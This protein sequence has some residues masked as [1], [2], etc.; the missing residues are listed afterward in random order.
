MIKDLISKERSKIESEG[1]NIAIW[2]KT[3]NKINTMLLDKIEELPNNVLN[4]VVDI[5][6]IN[7]I[8]GFPNIHEIFLETNS[9]TGYGIGIM[10]ANESPIHLDIEH[11]FFG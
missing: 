11:F 1:K 10:Y 3:N 4:N 2:P 5:E 6:L 8:E 7:Y 9:D